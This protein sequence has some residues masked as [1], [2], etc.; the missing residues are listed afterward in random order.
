MIDL[1]VLRDPGISDAAVDFLAL[2]ANQS[3]I[4]SRVLIR[5]R[6]VKAKTSE[7]AY[8]GNTEDTLFDLASAM[9]GY[10]DLVT[11]YDPGFFDGINTVR[12]KVGADVVA[13]LNP[14]ISSF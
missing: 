7:R 8:N 9:G 5:A 6:V 4:D 10:Q 1:L 13:Y 14:D 12:N 3:F 2:S 11:Q